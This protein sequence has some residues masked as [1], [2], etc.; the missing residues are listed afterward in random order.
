[1]EAAQS[2]VVGVDTSEESL[3][4][5]EWALH[6]GAH[7]RKRV[8]AVHAVGLLEGGHLRP[9][10]DLEEIVRAA[11]ADTAIGEDTVVDTVMAD[12]SAADVVRRVATREHA[13]V[14][15]V[16]SRGLGQATRVLGSTSEAVLASSTIPVL[17]VPAGSSPVQP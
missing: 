8:V 4:A 2:V 12:G 6:L 10:P 17:V 5:L 15:V 14:I 3:T 1:M 11:R 16:G 9:H 13:A 7:L